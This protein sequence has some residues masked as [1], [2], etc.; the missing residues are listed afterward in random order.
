VSALIVYVF[1]LGIPIM[2]KTFRQIM[3]GITGVL[4]VAYAI[5]M[6]V[7]AKKNVTAPVSAGVVEVVEMP[8]ATATGVETNNNGPIVVRDKGGTVKYQPLTSTAPVAPR[9]PYFGVGN[10]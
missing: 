2:S 4:L 9:N 8:V 7:S 3:S 10:K 1:E 5:F 6:V